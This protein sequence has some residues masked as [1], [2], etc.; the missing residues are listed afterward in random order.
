MKMR[1]I[2]IVV[3][4]VCG[5]FVAQA[6]A[7]SLTISQ[8]E[9]PYGAG[10]VF[11]DITGATFTSATDPSMS[12]FVA[13]GDVASWNHPD[14]SDSDYVYEGSLDDKESSATEDLMLT[15]DFGVGAAGQDFI[16]DL[17]MIVKDTVLA[18][19]K[20]NDFSWG[21]STD[22]APV[23]IVSD[24]WAAHSVEIFVKDPPTG[25]VG[26]GVRLGTFTADASGQISVWIG[27]AGTDGDTERTQIDG[28][29]VVPEP[30]TMLLLGLGSVVTLIRRK[31]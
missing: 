22:G 14:G 3:L 9:S 10:A 29:V 24:A 18:P 23:N 17:T 13:T 26:V 1:K 20:G 12:L 5:L 15:L 16:L 19:D 21:T 7:G 4:L 2:S 31:K 25:T 8:I 27:E 28:I 11:L 6:Q 30:A